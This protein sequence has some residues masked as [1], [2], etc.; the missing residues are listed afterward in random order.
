M[1]RPFSGL[2][3]AIRVRTSTVYSRTSL[4]QIMAPKS[5]KPCRSSRFP[6]DGSKV[7]L[8]DKRAS[9][10]LFCARIG[11]VGECLLSI[12]G[13]WF[14]CPIFLLFFMLLLAYEDDAIGVHFWLLIG[15]FSV[16]VS[17]WYTSLFHPSTKVAIMLYSPFSI[18]L[19]PILGGALLTFAGN[20]SMA[21]AYF[22]ITCWFCGEVPI[23]VLKKL[24]VRLP[25][26]A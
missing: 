9:S 20:R 19:S 23:L 25:S 3:H 14:G 22:F 16:L 18:L 13:C 26:S 24:A 21:S 2:P 1:C 7:D 5:E 8:L 12:P 4:S 6:A 11:L 10:F 17:L 15:S